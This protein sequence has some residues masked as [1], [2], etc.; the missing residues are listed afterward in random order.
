MK[1][2]Q[3]IFKETRAEV[4]GRKMQCTCDLD[5]WEPEAPT[6]HSW[7][8]RIHKAIVAE[9]NDKFQKRGRT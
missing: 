9:A 7:V 2:F 8:C 3:E 4:L 1:D 5:N 6:G